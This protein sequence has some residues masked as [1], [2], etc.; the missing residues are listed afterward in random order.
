MHTLDK[1]RKL[2]DE[3]LIGIDLSGNQLTLQPIN[4]SLDLGGKRLRP[5]LCLLGATCLREINHAIDPAIGIE[6]FHNFTLI[7]DDIMDE[8]PIR[9]GKETVYKKWNPNVAILSGDTM[10]ALAYNYIIKAPE[11]F[12]D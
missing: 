7:H 4:I 8:A 12:Q 1:Y 5:T 6:I 11:S 2:L 3:A 9:R 10:M